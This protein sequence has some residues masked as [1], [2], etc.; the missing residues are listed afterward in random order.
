M[1]GTDPVSIAQLLL[2]HRSVTPVDDGAQTT[3][4]GLLESLGFTAET[5][6]CGE[7]SNLVARRGTGS[8]H[9][10]FAGH[11]DV[12][13][14]G[15]DWRH[16]PFGGTIADGLLYGRGAVDMKG[17]IAAF[18]AALA[19]RPAYRAGTISLLITG[20][21]EGEAVDGTRRILDHL[22]ENRALPEFCLV[23]EPT[24]RTTLGD[25]IKIG[26]RGSVSA[27]ITVPGVQGHVA[28]PHLADNPLHRLIPALEALRTRQLDTG[29]AWFEPSS[30]QITSVDTGNAAGN[31][32]PASASARLNIRFNDCHKG[33][34]LAAWIRETVSTYAPGAKCETSISGEA[35]LTQPGKDIDL[36]S[37]AIATVTGITP[38]LDTGGGTSDARFITSYC[39]VAEFGLVGTSMHRVDEAVPISELRDLSEIYA[40]ILDRVFA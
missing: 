5:L 29:T 27:R 28:Y 3:L 30:L 7:V 37:D 20:D 6:Q 26:R 34:D 9:F 12:V 39:P 17:A 15:D 14:P 16:P 32:I 21:E 40:Q 18:V 4:A 31:V 23:G 35:F 33:T 25:T 24:C 11:T 10:A 1:T 22:A 8:P 19:S 13:P 38:K 2:R 36:L